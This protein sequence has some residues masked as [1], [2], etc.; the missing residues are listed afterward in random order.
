[1]SLSLLLATVALWGLIFLGNQ[2]ITRG[3]LR[4][5]NS[6]ITPL[7]VVLFDAAAIFFAKRSVKRRE[8]EWMGTLLGIIAILLL[9]LILYVA[10]TLIAWGGVSR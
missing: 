10:V 6:P 5:L 1:M 4:F 8:T 3:S 7:L 9:F 2:E